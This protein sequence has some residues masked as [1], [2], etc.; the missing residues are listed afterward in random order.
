M[1]VLDLFSGIGGFTLS[2]SW[3]WGDEL[4][5]VSFCEIDKRCRDFLAKTWPGVPIHDDIKTFSVDTFVNLCYDRLEPSEREEI[6]MASKNKNYDLAV[7]LYNSGLSIQDVADFYQIT[8][9]AMWMILKRRGCEFRSN[10]RF[11]KENHFHRG[12]TEAPDRVHNLT[13]LAIEKGVI[14]KQTHC[15]A[16]DS[17]KNIE[18]HHDDYNKP[19]EIRW[20]CHKCHFDWHS[21]NKPK[22]L[23]VTFPAKSRQEISAMGK[24]SQRLRKEMSHE[25]LQQKIKE[26]TRLDILTAGVP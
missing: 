24:Q 8:R 21:K 16:C 22:K 9:Q 19:L 25:E 18:A 6:D 15:S 3:V 17:T 12:G 1:R 5:I 14:V 2:A 20:L 11:G 4:E 13:E 26:A 10:L 7:N 23:T